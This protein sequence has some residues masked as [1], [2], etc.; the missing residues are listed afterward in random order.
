MNR[1]RTTFR[2]A[3]IDW[4]RKLLGLDE[5]G[6]INEIKRAYRRMCKQW[7][8]DSQG[9]EIS[10]SGKMQ[11]INAAYRLLLDYCE[12]YRCS[13]VP[14]QAHSFDPEEWWYR[15]FGE[16]IWSPASNEEKGE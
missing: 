13:F 8:P 5:R 14:E 10:G 7:H 9:S 12:H 6:S 11:E 16:N 3:D 1:T 15:R 2:A 4:A